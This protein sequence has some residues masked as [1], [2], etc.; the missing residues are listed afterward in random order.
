MNSLEWIGLYEAFERFEARAKSANF[1]VK[2][3]EA[4]GNELFALCPIPQ[5][6]PSPLYYEEYGDSAKE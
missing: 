2:E 4:M 3:I 6:K 1:R 5:P